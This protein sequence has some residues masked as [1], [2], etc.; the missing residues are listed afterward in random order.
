MGVSRRHVVAGAAGLAATQML[1][2]RAFATGEGI[3]ER[4]NILWFVSEDNNPFMG[5]YGDKL[6]H[7]PNFDAFAKRSVL[8]RYAYCTA[9]VCAC[10]RFGILTGVYPESCAPAN[11]MRSF[12]AHLPPEL[13]TYPQYMREAGYYTTNNWKTEY[14]CDVD[15]NAIWDDSSHKAHWRN[16]P[17]GVP[18]M[19]VFNYFTTHE[20][21]LFFRTPGRVKGKDVTVPGYLPDTPDVRDDIASYYNRMEILDTQFAARLK[22]LE[23]DGVA[24]D[25]I[26]FYY[27]DNGGVF[28]RSKRYCYEEGM[29]ICLMIH[30]PPKWQH[31]FPAPPGSEVDTPVSLIDLVPTLLSIIDMPR[32]EYMPGRALIGPYQGKPEAYAFGMRNRMDERYDF[33][34]TVGD[35]HSRYLRNYTPERPWGMHGAMEW[36]EKSYQ[37]WETEHLAHR[38]SKVQDRFFNSKPY[39]EFYDL[40]TD[41]DELHN[42]I[43][44]P[45]YADK[46]NAMRM[47][48]N[49]HML[50]I[51]DNGFIPEDSPEE[52]FFPS[53]D[54]G[55]YPLPTLMAM[56]EAAAK[57]DPRNLA[58]FRERLSSKNEVIRYWAA[59]GLMM[60]GEAAMPAKPDLEKLMTT[61]PSLHVQIVAS[62]T[63]AQLGTPEVAVKHLGDIMM[64]DRRY[65]VP[66]Q[67]INA[68]T[69]IGAPA[70]AVMPQL[71]V[72]A[73]NK[74][75]YLGE[76]A[77]Y[78]VDILNGTYRPDKVLFN[79]DSIP[80]AWRG[81][82]PPPTP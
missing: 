67:A 75:E 35:G 62:Q 80:P 46:I 41:P 21:Q 27:S 45:R 68:L 22:Q 50:E 1:A 56:G 51:N 36:Q 2:S 66:L 44:D 6:A 31:L 20:S 57:R 14:N 54:R 70:K 63:V 34:R 26:I 55:K 16:R 29:R 11:T 65:P 24:D 13:K 72:M 30:V 25:T 58:M 32:S 48:L 8:Y 82:I 81:E 53:R 61:D 47:A 17:E 7:T 71:Q 40:D 23:D 39:E 60:L 4:P 79:V 38:D 19:S 9:P 33:V 10:S 28:P 73:K 52:G 43:D 37:S 78:L 59:M 3:R 42:L 76:A 69:F 49:R 15:P 12:H 18:F 77:R 5:C 74:N 64:L